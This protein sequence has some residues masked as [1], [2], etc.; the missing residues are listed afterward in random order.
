[1]RVHVIE[2]SAVIRKIISKMIDAE[3]D[4][5]AIGTTRDGGDRDQRALELMPDLITIDSQTPKKNGIIALRE[6]K[7]ECHALNPAVLM[8]SSLTSLKG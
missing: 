1:M 3:P 6:I 7:A 2:D 4:I 5:E 8:C